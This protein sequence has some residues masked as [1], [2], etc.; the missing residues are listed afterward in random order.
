MRI[1]WLVLVAACQEDIS[2]PFP[3]GLEPFEDDA[4]PLTLDDTPAEELR[5]RTTDD[6]MIRV[7]GR[8]FIFAQPATVYAAAHDPY[9]MIAVCATTS[10]GIAFNNDPEY[11]L[12]Y[13]IHYY[14]DDIV[15]VEWE[16]QWRAGV[17]TGP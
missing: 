15:D 16:D 7:Y 17:I 10:Q 13:L 8:G 1:A 5:S 6:G 9:V 14:V 2:T 3:P 12:S 11:E 4:E